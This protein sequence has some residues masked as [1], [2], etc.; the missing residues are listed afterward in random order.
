MEGDTDPNVLG[1]EL[2]LVVER[3]SDAGFESA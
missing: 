1:R 3:F 2:E